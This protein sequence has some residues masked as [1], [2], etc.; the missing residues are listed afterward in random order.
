MAARKLKWLLL[1]REW[2]KEER[3]TPLPFSTL[4]L[5]ETYAYH[6]SEA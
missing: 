1:S 3:Y 2:G 6:P 5:I 4:S